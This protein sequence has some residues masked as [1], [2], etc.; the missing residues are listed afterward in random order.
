MERAANQVKTA[1]GMKGGSLYFTSGGTESN[2]L[3]IIGAA[4]AKKRR[5]N[6]VI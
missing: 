4:E 2:N 5:G 3:A 1:L 6:R